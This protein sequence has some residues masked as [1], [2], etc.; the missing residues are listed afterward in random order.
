MAGQ[1]NSALIDNLYQ[2]LLG[3]APD[4]GGYAH[5]DAMINQPNG[6]DAARN[7]I[8]NSVEGR[9]YLLGDGYRDYARA[10][11]AGINQMPYVFSDTAAFV[12]GYRDVPKSP[13]ETLFGPSAG[14]TTIDNVQG[15]LESIFAP[16]KKDDTSNQKSTDNTSQSLP[17]LAPGRWGV[18]WAGSGSGGR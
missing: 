13:L 15:L 4:A 10:S 16:K 6:Y 14:Q 17:G 1:T 11:T 9:N 3:R 18:D 8:M 2:S 5:Y 12:P 7:E